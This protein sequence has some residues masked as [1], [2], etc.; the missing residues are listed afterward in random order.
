MVYPAPGWPR[1]R[2]RRVAELR[3][4]G[5]GDFYVIPDSF[6]NPALRSGVS[7]GIS[8]PRRRPR[9]MWAS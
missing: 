2:E 3:R 9:P 7:L 8:A 5:I 1:G 6:P 4:L